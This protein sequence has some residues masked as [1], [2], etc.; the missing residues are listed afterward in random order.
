[1]MGEREDAMT[2]AG[3]KSEGKESSQGRRRGGD[4]GIACKSIPDR[5]R[6]SESEER[7]REGCLMHESGADCCPDSDCCHP[8]SLRSAAAADR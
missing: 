8:L 1:M 5:H 3:G 6:Q 7:E 2:R 4:Q